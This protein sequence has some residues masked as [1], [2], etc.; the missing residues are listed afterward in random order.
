MKNYLTAAFLVTFFVTTVVEAP[1][2][3]IENFGVVPLLRLA[4]FL[5]APMALCLA[6]RRFSVTAVLEAINISSKKNQKLLNLKLFNLT[7]GLLFVK[8]FLPE[9]YAL[10]TSEVP[11]DYV[12]AKGEQK[13][14]SI[15]ELKTFSVGNREVISYKLLKNRKKLL[16]KGK[17]IGFTDIVVWTSR[18]KIV[19]NLYVL[20][21]QNFLKT[22]QLADALKNLNLKLDIRGPIMTASGTIHHFSD[23]L[24]LQKIKSLYN[25]QIFLK[26]KLNSKL[27]NQIISKIYKRL[28]TN[29]ISSLSCQIEWLNISCFYH[30]F[31]NEKILK[32]LNSIYKIS[33]IKEDSKNKNKNFRLR[34]K[35]IQLEKMNGEEIHIGLDKLRAS[36]RDLFDQGLKKL[37]DDNIVYLTKAKMDLSSLAEPELILSM[38]T[39]QQIEIGSQIPYQNINT[40]GSAVVAPIDWRFAGLKIKTKIT[41]HFGR[42]L[43]QYETEFTRPVDQSIS[44]S[45]EKASVFLEIDKP[46]KI[47]QIG[48]QTTSKSRQG[49]PFLSE[50]PILKNIFE[51]KSDQKTYKQIYGYVVIEESN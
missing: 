36:I 1:S 27:R 40:Q 2:S 48:F 31:I 28:Y 25:N 29:Q 35:L 43:L 16:I 18:G 44:G 20:S 17:K 19:Y 46:L 4:A 24:Y 11:K 38:E 6:L 49:I 42:L 23:Y 34:L 51:S 7:V 37:V 15:M 13:E 21:K 26:I 32:E 14:I 3:W 22:F 5:L 30:G 41:D 33:F 9:C 39:P 8:A 10:E 50:L 45:K 12:L 47:F